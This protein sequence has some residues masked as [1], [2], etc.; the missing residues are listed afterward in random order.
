MITFVRT[1]SIAPGKVPECLAFARTIA[2]LAEE[3]F[4]LDI[5]LDMPVGGD[6]NRIAFVSEYVNLAE[7]ESTIGKFTGDAE[8][9]KLVA[10]NAANV[11][12]GS[13]FDEIWRSV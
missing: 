9:L 1:I 6:P 7:Y 4:D 2:K 5:R 11:I 3:K 8:Y 12:P 13:T 10:N